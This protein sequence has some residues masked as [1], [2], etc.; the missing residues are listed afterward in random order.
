VVSPVE[1]TVK[2]ASYFWTDMSG[3]KV[4]TLQC[5]DSLL[6][7][8]RIE[9]LSSRPTRPLLPA[10]DFVC[11]CSPYSALATLQLQDLKA[12]GFSGGL[13]WKHRP[14][15]GDL[16]LVAPS[17]IVMQLA[18]GGH[19]PSAT[20]YVKEVGEVVVQSFEE[21]FLFVLAH[22]ARHIQQFWSTAIKGRKAEVDAELFARDILRAWRER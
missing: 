12:Q 21:E 15:L 10:I 6:L 16:A 5:G 7:G 14:Q 3:Q 8:V 2:L 17:L 20:V 18:K 11:K 1:V 9:N 13:A 22:E 19:Y 4:V